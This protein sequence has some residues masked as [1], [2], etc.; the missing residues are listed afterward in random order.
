LLTGD[1]ILVLLGCLGLAAC[2]APGA[3][4][5]VPTPSPTPTPDLAARYTELVQPPN[6]AG[7]RLRAASD[8]PAAT[9]ASLRPAAQA[10]LDS[11]VQLD[12]DL[13]AFQDQVPAA[14]KADVA[15]LRQTLSRDETDVRSMIAST[16]VPQFTAAYAKL[17]TDDSGQAATTVRSDLGLDAGNP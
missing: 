16:S 10:F 13:V 11:L 14:D 7:D 6:D 2:S 12:H 1:R 8:D 3:T 15:A 5:L 4:T 9:I 17:T